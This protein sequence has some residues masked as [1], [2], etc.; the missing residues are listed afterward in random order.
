MKKIHFLLPFL[1]LLISV[2]GCGDSKSIR[3][4]FIGTPWVQAP[5]ASSLPTVT[6]TFSEHEFNGFSGVNE[7]FGTYTLNKKALTLQK[8]GVTRKTGDPK[9]MQAEAD[10]LDRFETVVEYKIK[11]DTLVLIN[12]SGQT[13]LTLTA[14]ALAQTQWELQR[15][16]AENETGLQPVSAAFEAPP[17]LSF[18]PDEK[19]AGNDGINDFF[20]T[21]LTHGNTLT[22][23]SQGAT[24]AAGDPAAMAL[25][26]SF[27]HQ[28]IRTVSFTLTGAWLTLYDIEGT[29][30][31]ELKQLPPPVPETPAPAKAEAAAGTEAEAAPDAA[32]PAGEPVSSSQPEAA[33]ATG[34]DSVDRKSVV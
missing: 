27:Q 2:M 22:L 1:W 20:G 17:S 16:A 32:A 33:Q 8:V 34:R 28:L 15:L 10:F 7:F 19:Y 4:S 3:L 6:L 23:T 11:G 5:S 30:L 29:P 31:A 18:L 25:A 21:Y 13:Q 9:A 24:M 26:D 14:F 12:E